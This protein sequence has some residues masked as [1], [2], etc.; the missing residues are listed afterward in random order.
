MEH[1]LKGYAED[2]T[3]ISCDID[4]RE[5]VLHVID[6]KAADLDLSFKPPKC[7]SFSFDGANICTHSILR[8]NQIHHKRASN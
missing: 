6:L 1:Y 4:V 3:L 8:H 5:S 2:V 7:V